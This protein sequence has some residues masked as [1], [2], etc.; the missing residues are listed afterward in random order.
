VP[1]YRGARGNPIVLAHDHRQRILAGERNLGCKRLIENNPDLVTALEMA[2]D[3]VVFDL[4][5]EQAYR[6]LQHRLGDSSAP[7]NVSN[8]A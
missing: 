4:D 6:Q 2:N 8:F 1:T 3:H 7:Q 5:T